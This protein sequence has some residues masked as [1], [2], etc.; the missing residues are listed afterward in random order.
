MPIWWIS[1][2]R[3]ASFGWN[4]FNI[5]LQPHARYILGNEGGIEL[6]PVLGETRAEARRI[7]HR[8]FPPWRYIRYDFARMPLFLK[9]LLPPSLMERT[10]P[11]YYRLADT[12]REEEMYEIYAEFFRRL[13]DRTKNLVIVTNDEVFD[14][15]AR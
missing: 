13:A 1:S 11:L 3:D 12:A 6:L 7:Y 14:S 5:Y 8:L 9:L 15:M 2:G 10:N 4:A